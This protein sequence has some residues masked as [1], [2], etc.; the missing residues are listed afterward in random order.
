MSNKDRFLNINIMFLK[1]LVIA[2]Y[3]N[4]IFFTEFYLVQAVK[5][6]SKEICQ[7]FL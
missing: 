1:L 3:R 7:I 4:Q 2:Q 6:F 5:R